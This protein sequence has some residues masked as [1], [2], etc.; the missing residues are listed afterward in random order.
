VSK[1]FNSRGQVSG[2]PED[3]PQR[4][5]KRKEASLAQE[6]QGLT[7]K[8]QR[9]RGQ[10]TIAVGTVVLVKVEDVDRGKTDSRYVP[11]VVV[12]LTTHDFCR[13]GC[14]GGV[15]KDCYR[16]ETLLV[17]HN[18]GPEVYNLQGVLKDWSSL[19]KISVREALR[20]ISPSGGQGFTKC[21]CNGDCSK[22]NCKCRKTGVLC[23]SR[24]H[25]G[26]VTCKNC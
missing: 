12:E 3:S 11:G 14:K 8:R 19:P 24:C 26:S 4:G 5:A 15:L 7:M 6:K 17:E 25:G 21:G 23:N 22:S 1:T 20:L 13:I 9:N 2:P 10:P 16:P 18:H